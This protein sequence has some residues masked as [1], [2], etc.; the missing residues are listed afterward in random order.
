MKMC[1][2][3]QRWQPHPDT[4]QNVVAALVYRPESPI[5][6]ELSIGYY[7]PAQGQSIA[8][9]QEWSRLGVSSTMPHGLHS[10]A[11]SYM[12][13]WAVD[14]CPSLPETLPVFERYH[15]EATEAIKEWCN[16]QG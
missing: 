4:G 8:T 2:L 15:R 9:V 10:L 6:W 13:S 16:A 14:Q 7:D 5:C 3:A 1:V 12:F 11:E